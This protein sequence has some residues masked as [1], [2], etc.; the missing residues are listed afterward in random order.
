[1][2]TITFSLISLFFVKP[3]LYKTEILSPFFGILFFLI[4]IVMFAYFIYF[5]SRSIQINIYIQ[6]LAK[7][8]VVLID[9]K[10]DII[11]RDPRISC[12]TLDKFDDLMEKDSIEI[13]TLRSGFIQLF[14]EKKLYDFAEENNAVIW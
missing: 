5:I 11:E 12:D 9:K 4:A 1:M 3:Q 13:K 6:D 8:T 14:E 7:E 2:S 10:L